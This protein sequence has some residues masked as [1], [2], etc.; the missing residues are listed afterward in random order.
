MRY[1]Y[2]VRIQAPPVQVSV[3][4]PM[5][6][7]WD[8]CGD[9]SGSRSSQECARCDGLELSLVELNLFCKVGHSANVSTHS[10]IT[11]PT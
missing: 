5:K 8:Q 6:R 4:W 3:L 9:R 10:K 11:S 7:D 2:A 1:Y